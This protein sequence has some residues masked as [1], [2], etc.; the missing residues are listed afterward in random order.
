L[1]NYRQHL[2]F[3]SVLG[4][5]YAAGAFFVVG[6]HWVYGSVAALLATM[7]GL[8]PD[9]DSGTGVEL[10]AFT[11][12]LGVLAALFVWMGMSHLDPPPVFEMH[13]WAM[14]LAYVVVRHGIRRFARHFSVH[15]G[16]S[17]SFPTCG[18]WG[19]LTY[20]YYPSDWHSI[21]L[22][23][24]AAVMLG[25]LSHLLLDEICSV[26][27]KGARVNKAFGTAMKFWAPSVWSTL[28]VY[29]LLSLLA[30]QVV[31][32]WPED[33]F[34]ITPPP[35]PVIPY[36]AHARQLKAFALE[37]EGDPAVQ[38]RIDQLKSIEPGLERAIHT[39]APAVEKELRAFV[40]ETRLENATTKL[41]R[42]F[43]DTG[44]KA[45]PQRPL[46]PTVRTMPPAP[47]PRPERFRPLRRAL[48]NLAPGENH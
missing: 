18:V 36:S 37:V 30:W 14:V 45:N 7:S 23:M 28:A 9:L 38:S 25:F 4:V 10:K 12:V 3:A 8:L 11:G 1:G 24:A 31:K 19:A 17:H 39:Y 29:G 2:T 47:V 15:R 41:D 42:T 48:R 21:R 22:M 44:V 40:P 43:D 35:P 26:D 34:R 16:M 32:V 20:L 27:L 5:G 6:V 13:L 46:P 33:A